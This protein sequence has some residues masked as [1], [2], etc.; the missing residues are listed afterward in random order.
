VD[1]G[2]LPE[3]R[4]D[5]R[6]TLNNVATWGL[7]GIGLVGVVIG[8][9]DIFVE[10]GQ[11]LSFL[12]KP[13]DILL[14]M[15][16]SLA[17]GLGIERLATM[18]ELEAEIR[19][20]HSDMVEAFNAVQQVLVTA[21]PFRV[22]TSEK[23][24][25]EEA[26][27]IINVCKDSDI[28][29][30][31]GLTPEA[32]TQQQGSTVQFQSYLSTIAK[33]IKKAKEQGGSLSYRVVL[34]SERDRQQSIQIRRDVCSSEGVLDRLVIKSVEMTWPL[35]ILLVGDS[36]IIGFVSL[37][38]DLTFRVGVRVTNRDLIRHVSEWYDDFLWN[39]AKSETSE[40]S[41]A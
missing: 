41:A 14:I 22:L 29:R 32:L 6:N 37:T 17:L 19:R 15:V 13:Q 4:R 35:E 26:I 16:A 2:K 5:W 12:K 8:A 18:G 1:R 9:L 34:G 10:L 21:V 24:I 38:G 23:A 11:F 28:I 33:R 30:A 31:T 20:T 36:M 39:A 40:V 25:F 27:H 3:S 7:I